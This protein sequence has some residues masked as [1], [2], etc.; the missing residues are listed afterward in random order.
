MAVHVPLLLIIGTAVVAVHVAATEAV[1]LP[2]AVTTR[3]ATLLAALVAP[4][5]APSSVAAVAVIAIT[6]T[7]VAAAGRHWH[8]F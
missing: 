6:V 4:T 1:V 8:W 2:A 5:D 7:V 3:T